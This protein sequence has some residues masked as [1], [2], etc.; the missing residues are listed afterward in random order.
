MSEFPAM[1]SE[2]A[3]VPN[4][5]NRQPLYLA[6]Y[7]A[8]REALHERSWQVGASLPSEAELSSTY[9]VSRITVRHALRLLEGEGYI[10]KA[11]ARRPVVIATTPPDRTGWSVH[12]IEDIVALAGR[13]TLDVRSWRKERSATD[14]RHLAVPAMTPLYCLRSVLVRDRRP[15]ARSIIY[16]PPAIGSRLSLGAFDDPV[17]F[18]VLQRDLGVRL[19]DVKLTIWA[20]LANADDAVCLGCEIGAALLVTQLLYQDVAG[21]AVEVAYSRSLASALKLSTRL[22]AAARNP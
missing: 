18:R 12:S 4:P 14:S 19:D 15:Y 1:P 11:R 17:V 22:S 13:A 16:F 8:L 20:E 5:G 10:R 21:T 6:V 3:D 2:V 9:R 7:A